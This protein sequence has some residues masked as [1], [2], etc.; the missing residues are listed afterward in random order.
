MADEN[1]E[2][3]TQIEDVAVA[4]DGDTVP[5]A[6]PA[7]GK[8]KMFANAP[9]FSLSRIQ[10]RSGPRGRLVSG[11]SSSSSFNSISKETI[12]TFLFIID[13]AMLVDDDDEKALLSNNFSHLFMYMHY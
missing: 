6:A 2:N 9:F 4:K 7:A 3:E 12:A 8:L 10:P 5:I 1:N 11:S 13:T